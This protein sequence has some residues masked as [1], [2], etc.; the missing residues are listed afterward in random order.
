V[1]KKRKMKKKEKMK[2]EKEK[3]TIFLL[4]LFRLFLYFDYSGFH[5]NRR[6]TISPYRLNVRPPN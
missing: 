2:K 1:A 5:H 4:I 6:P 3:P